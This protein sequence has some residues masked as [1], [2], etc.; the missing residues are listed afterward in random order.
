MTWQITVEPATEPITLS[1]AKDWLK[2]STSAD[3]ALITALIKAARIH[4]EKYTGRLLITQTVK[5]YHDYFP[6]NGILQLYFQPTT[7]SSVKYT[8][9]DGDLETLS[10]SDYTA[11]IISRPSRIVVN[12]GKNWPTTGEYPNAVTVEYAS[13]FANAAAVPETFKIGMKLLLAFWYENREDIPI[14][15]SNDPRIRSYHNALFC[16]KVIA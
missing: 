6:A 11:D 15:G 3:D 10:A 13:G 4:T 14:S 2:V 7:V 1:E 5:E 16:E 9:S 8:D 12:P